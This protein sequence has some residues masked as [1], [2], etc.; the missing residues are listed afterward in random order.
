MRRK[1]QEVVGSYDLGCECA[2]LVLREGTSGEF[3]T[4]PEKNHIPRIK[5]GADYKY[6]YEVVIALTHECMELSLLRQG[7]RFEPGNSMG[8]D[9]AAYLFVADHTKFSE[10]CAM[11]GDYLAAALPDLAKA[12]KKWQARKKG[13]KNA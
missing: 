12:W 13:A 10:C 8:R 9:S 4:K 7:C 11:T 5:I 2:Q 6:W 1:T 3:F